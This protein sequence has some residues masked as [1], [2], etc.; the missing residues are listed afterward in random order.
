M[1]DAQKSAFASF[2]RCWEP[3][4]PVL[5]FMAWRW[6]KRASNL[7][8]AGITISKPRKARH[9]CGQISGW[10]MFSPLS[11]AEHK[12]QLYRNH[13]THWHSRDNLLTSRIFFSFSAWESFRECGVI[14]PLATFSLI[15]CTLI[16]YSSTFKKKPTLP[17]SST[18]S[19]FL[20]KKKVF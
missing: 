11:A 13:G 14:M 20:D 10:H 5:Y 18:S 9:C 8:R 4:V 17:P 12:P 6:Y 2:D 7:S 1:G 19:A 15:F 16:F 3:W